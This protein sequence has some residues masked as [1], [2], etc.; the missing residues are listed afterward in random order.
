MPRFLLSPCPMASNREAVVRFAIPGSYL[1]FKFKQRRE[2]LPPCLPPG[3]EPN[4]SHV[5]HLIYLILENMYDDCYDINKDDELNIGD[6][7][8]LINIIL[9]L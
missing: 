2:S 3:E 9:K 4:I 5:N 7:N 6:V 8:A 1:D